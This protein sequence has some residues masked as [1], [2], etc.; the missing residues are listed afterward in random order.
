MRGRWSHNNFLH[1]HD[2]FYVAQPCCTTKLL[3]VWTHLY[4]ESTLLSVTS[5]LVCKQS[6]CTSRHFVGMYRQQSSLDFSRLSL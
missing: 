3:S 5:L 1:D 6:V 2:T 4:S